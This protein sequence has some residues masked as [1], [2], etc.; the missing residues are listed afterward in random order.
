[1]RVTLLDGAFDNHIG[2]AYTD[3]RQHEFDPTAPEIGDN[4]VTDTIGHRLARRLE[5]QIRAGARR[6]LLFGIDA[7]QDSIINSPITASI[8]DQGGFMEW[9]GRIVGELFWPGERALRP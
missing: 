3:D 6:K 7:E 1:V 8:G 5:R 2:V 9:Q 4:P